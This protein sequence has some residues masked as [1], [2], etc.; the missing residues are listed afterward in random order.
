MEYEYQVEGQ[1][2]TSRILSL[3]DLAVLRLQHGFRSKGVAN[4]IAR[5]YPKGKVVT[6]QY[7]PKK[8]GLAILNPDVF[9]VNLILIAL[10][11]LVPVLFVILALWVLL[12][13]A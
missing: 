11:F 5:K 6:V 2:Y 7:D 12:V 9:N 3:T 10:S 4:R 13:K 8:P 1:I